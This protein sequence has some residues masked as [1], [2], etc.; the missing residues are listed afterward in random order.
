MKRIDI[1][2]HAVKGMIS[3]SMLSRGLKISYSKASRLMDN[4]E[5]WGYVEAKDGNGKRKVI[6]QSEV[7]YGKGE[8]I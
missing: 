4:L 7:S 5:A 1:M 2:S 6:K 8:R 3:T